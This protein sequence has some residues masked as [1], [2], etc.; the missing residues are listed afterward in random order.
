MEVKGK[1]QSIVSHS[2][3]V[4][5]DEFAYSDVDRL[6]SFYHKTK[7]NGRWLAVSL[8]QAYLLNAVRK[9]SKLMIPNLDESNVIVFESRRYA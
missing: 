3:G 6:N 8:K 4:V 5:L 1:L 9:N 2:D 7:E